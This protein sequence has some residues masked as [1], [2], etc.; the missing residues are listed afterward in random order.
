MTESTVV[1]P[2]SLLGGAITLVGLSRQ[3]KQP[4]GACLV[5]QMDAHCCC[6][7]RPKPMTAFVNEV[8]AA[9]RLTGVV[10]AMD[11]SAEG[12]QAGRFHKWYL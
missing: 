9:G 4:A 3:A 12:A 1:A 7:R 11:Q 8:P 2:A 10:G 5:T 6:C